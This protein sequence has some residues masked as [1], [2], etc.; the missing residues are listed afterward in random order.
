MHWE[1]GGQVGMTKRKVIEGPAPAARVLRKCSTSPWD[2]EVT[3]S[4][5]IK[6]SPA[7]LRISSMAMYLS[8]DSELGLSS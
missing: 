1:H 2:E 6:G 5:S 3:Q 8:V 7:L 4:I